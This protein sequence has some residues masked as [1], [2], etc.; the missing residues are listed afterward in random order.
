MEGRNQ[1]P[2]AITLY[3]A[4]TNTNVQSAWPEGFRISLQE[5]KS[6]P[7][8]RKVKAEAMAAASPM[9]ALRFTAAPV[10]LADAAELE[11]PE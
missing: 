5:S 8:I 1:W 4:N 9:G 7:Q 11:A 10:E 2:W 6:G 3:T